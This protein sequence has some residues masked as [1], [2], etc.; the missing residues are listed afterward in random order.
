MM[1]EVLP[2]RIMELVYSVL[3]VTVVDVVVVARS[4]LF[5]TEIRSYSCTRS[6]KLNDC[7]FL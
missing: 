2:G 7:L 3:I 4:G 5:V 6:C 1:E